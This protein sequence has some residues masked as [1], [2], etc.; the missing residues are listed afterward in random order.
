M[1]HKPDCPWKDGFS[2]TLI[3]LNNNGH[4]INLSIVEDC[5]YRFNINGP[6]N[7]LYIRF[8]FCPMCGVS[9]KD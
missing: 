3:S 6:K 9:F 2:E 4:D 5:I 1:E 7:E 8:N